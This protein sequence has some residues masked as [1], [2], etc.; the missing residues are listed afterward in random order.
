MKGPAGVGKSAVAQTCAEEL[1]HTE[2]LGATFF[3]SISG[4]DKLQVSR[5]SDPQRFFPSIAYQLSTI[6]PPYRDLLNEKIGHDKTLINKAPSFQFQYLIEE[7]LRELASQ[8]KG[9]G[10]RT[11]II[12]DGLDECE[13]SSAQVEI[14]HIVARAA[15][16]NTFPLCWAFFSRSEPHI[17]ATFLKPSITTHCYKIV[18]PISRDADGE[19]EQYLRNGF[20]NILEQHNASVETQWPSIEDMAILVSAASGSFIYATTVLRFVDCLSLPGP[21]KRLCILIDTILERRKHSHDAG[22]G[23]DRLFAE[24]DA[25]YMLIL[26]RIPTAIFPSVH[27]LL[28]MMCQSGTSSV[29]YV[30]NILGLSKDEFE[31]VCNHASAV[32]HLKDPGKDLELYPTI[33]TKSTYTQ[34]DRDVLQKIIVPVYSDLGGEVDFY[35]K[36]FNDFLLDPSRSGTFCVKDSEALAK[37]SL[38]MYRDYDR[39]YGWE[40]SGMFAPIHFSN[41]NS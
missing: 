12:I 39:S 25:F 36:S 38:K 28:A 26:Q 24:L 31:T 13:G 4:R 5:R 33:D 1:K 6:H 40:G 11:V 20:K 34:A 22:T 29:L 41:P 14:I 35:H 32:V 23:V 19:I 7:P 30:A 10:Q 17:E 18:L 37:H 16:N 3:F 8:G 2:R 15:S 27:L 21:Q 9:I